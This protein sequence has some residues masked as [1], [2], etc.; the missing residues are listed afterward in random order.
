MDEY[1][2]QAKDFLKATNSKIELELKGFEPMPWDKDGQKRNVWNVTLSNSKGSFDFTYGDSINNSCVSDP[3]PDKN[4]EYS[5]GF[6]YGFASPVKIVGSRSITMKRNT[7]D[8]QHTHWDKIKYDELMELK[9]DEKAR[10]S[11]IERHI[12]LMH[13]SVE[14]A[15]NELVE[16]KKI[17]KKD[18]SWMTRKLIHDKAEEKIK[19]NIERQAIVIGEDYTAQKTPI[20]QPS[21]Y[22]LLACISVSYCEDFNDFCC[23]F[24]Y[25]NDSISALNTWKEVRRQDIEL[26]KLY[27]EKELEMLHEIV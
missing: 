9:N 25:D 13:E 2:K 21:A 5:I 7:I 23:E 15:V 24:G 14:K 20:H 3:Q 16:Q 8:F 17:S 10:S 27:D 1:I 19:H 12:N 26:Q 18:V 22:S 6:G 4:H 11:F